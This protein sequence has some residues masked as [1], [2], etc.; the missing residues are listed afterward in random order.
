[1]EY[2]NPEALSETEWLARNLDN[3]D[4]KIVDCT[5]AMPGITIV[6]EDEYY[7][8]HIPGAVWFDINDIADDPA[9]K[10]HMLPTAEVFAEKVGRLG[11]SADDHVVV[12]DQIGGMSAAARV[13]W[14]FRCFGHAKVSWLNGSFTK[15]EAE[16]HPVTADITSIMP[17]IYTAKP[18]NS[19]L[20][21]S[22][23]QM[24]ENVTSHAEQ[25]I[26]ARANPRFTGEDPGPNP[27]LSAGHIPGSVNVPYKVLLNPE[28]GTMLPADD[29]TDI[30]S[31][32]GVNLGLPISNSCGSGVTA[33]IP[34]LALYL[35][36]NT[37][38]AV[39]DGSWNEWG[40]QSDTP[41]EKG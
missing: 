6:A 29:L 28:N 8:K 39:Y 10:N 11:I 36:G 32:Q 14:M 25:V 2:T 22:L 19:G 41:V 37:N 9:R 1:M 17:T 27:K 3:P 34:L 26:D 7:K 21:R 38:A 5:Y 12:Y 13:W 20:V 40:A 30:F 15:W 33:N 23:E 4:I 16:I 35:L 31:G 18:L 24:K